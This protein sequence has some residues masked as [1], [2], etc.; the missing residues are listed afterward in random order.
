MHYIVAAHRNQRIT[1]AIACA[2]AEWMGFLRFTFFLFTSD[3]A[4]F[5]FRLARDFAANCVHAQPNNKT[6]CSCWFFVRRV[7]GKRYLLRVAFIGCTRADPHPNHRRIDRGSYAV[8]VHESV[9]QFLLHTQKKTCAM[10][11]WTRCALWGASWICV[12]ISAT[13]STLAHIWIS[14]SNRS[15]S[16]AHVQKQLKRSWNARTIFTFN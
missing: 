6:A 5:S 8:Y 3:R 1:L 15:T 4:C 13:R 2:C 12:F 9:V 11:I 7:F 16:G 14:S 10:F